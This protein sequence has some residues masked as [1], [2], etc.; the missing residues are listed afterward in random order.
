M[1]LPRPRLNRITALTAASLIAF[2]A[3]ASDGETAGP[4]ATTPATAAPDLDDVETRDD[5]LTPNDMTH[6]G[7]TWFSPPPP[8]STATVNDRWTEATDASSV[9]RVMFDW[10]DVEPEEGDRRFVEL[11]ES[12]AEMV[13][14]GRAPMASIVAVDVSGTE[15]PEWLGGFEPQRAAD[16]YVA[17]VQD[18]LPI[19][20]RHEVWT[21]SIANEPPLA[22]DDGLDR[23]Q[24]A[25]FVEQVVDQLQEIAP[26]LA[27]TFTFAGG[28]PFID[29]PAIDRMVDAVDVYSVNHY[30]LDA[31]LRAVPLDEAADRIDEHVE[32]AGDLP[33]V[34]QE[35][36]CP[37]GELMG[38]SDDFQLAWFGEAFDH[39]GEID[40]VRAAFVFE[41]L[42]WSADT[43]ELGYGEVEQLL[44]DEVGQDFV[45]RFR[46]WLLTSGLV[47]QDGTTRPAFDHFLEVAAG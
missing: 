2:A 44:V 19:L 12:L 16:A 26:D 4:A 15:F 13:D 3:C 28:D 42:D 46:E 31:F 7:L 35:F 32:R 37:A 23:G 47:R 45:D 22:D 30:C 27:V 11:D 29:D 20:E 17:M 8:D 5:V 40:Q 39:I 21:L 43:Y 41:F 33:I 36:G 14:S 1:N 6:L 10:I 38:S 34:F 24:F 18:V 9:G 25:M